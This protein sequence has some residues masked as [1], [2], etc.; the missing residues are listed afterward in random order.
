MRKKIFWGAAVTAVAG[1]LLVWTARASE[2]L[3]DK[4]MSLAGLEAMYV[5][6]QGVTEDTK[7]VGLSAERIQ[8]EV[9]KK[10]KEIGI[11]AMSEEE[12]VRTAGSPTVYVNISAYRKRPKAPFVFHVDVG[13]LQEVSLVRDSKI[14]TMSITWNKGRLGQCPPRGL[15]KAMR[16]SVGYLMDK[17]G[18]DYQAANKP[19]DIII[20]DSNSVDREDI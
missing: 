13:I 14:R 20:Y 5:F 10:L 12:S 11:R 19:P 3:T 6:V 17:F 4:Q 15:V 16:E 8:T 1:V 18:D 9:G 7:R 2:K